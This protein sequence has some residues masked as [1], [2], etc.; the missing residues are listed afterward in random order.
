MIQIHCVKKSYTYEGRACHR[1]CL[2][3]V[4]K[5]EKQLFIKKTVEVGQ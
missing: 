5:L 2:A 3:F 1:I 4:D